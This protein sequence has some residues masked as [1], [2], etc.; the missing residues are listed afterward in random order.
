LSGR[1]VGDTLLV[2]TVDVGST[3]VDITIISKQFNNTYYYS[4]SASVR[5]FSKFRGYLTDLYI[6]CVVR[7][8]LYY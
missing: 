4:D 7:N 1:H 5:S 2:A 8:H 6:F 3:K